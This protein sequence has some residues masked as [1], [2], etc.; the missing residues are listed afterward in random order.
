MV[1]GRGIVLLL[2][3]CM[4]VEGHR[5]G[6]DPRVPAHP[7]GAL[8]DAVPATLAPFPGLCIALSFGLGRCLASRALML[9]SDRLGRRILSNAGSS[10][11][12]LL[13]LVCRDA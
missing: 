10:L 5:R 4:L 6:I 3:G 11:F 7:T 13:K 2:L 9:L 1:S 12:E 8:A